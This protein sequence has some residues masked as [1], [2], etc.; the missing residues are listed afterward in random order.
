MFTS[1]TYSARIH[2]CT[3]HLGVYR[4]EAAE[5]A[6]GQRQYTYK[7]RAVYELCCFCVVDY[8]DLRA[9]RTKAVLPHTRIILPGNE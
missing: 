6:R 2:I 7:Y 5:T 1:L 9:A 4:V 3:Y 8:G